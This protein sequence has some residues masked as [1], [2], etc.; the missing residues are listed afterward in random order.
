M[1]YV[2]RARLLPDDP[3][4][5]LYLYWTSVIIEIWEVQAHLGSSQRN[6]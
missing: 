3:Q 6:G 1:R 5:L 2:F 4:S